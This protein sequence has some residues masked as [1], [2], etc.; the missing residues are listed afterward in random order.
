MRPP[1]DSIA[2]DHHTLTDETTMPVIVEKSIKQAFTVSCRGSGPAAR[3]RSTGD[4]CPSAGRTQ[5]LSALP[6]ISAVAL[7][8]PALG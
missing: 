7:G 2:I 8:A 6:A 1:L 5:T 4:A 3:A